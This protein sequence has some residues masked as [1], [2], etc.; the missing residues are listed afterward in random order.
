MSRQKRYVYKF[1][2]PN[3]MVY[4]GVT[5]DP[6]TRWQYNGVLY[7]PQAV[8]KAIKRFG[9]ENIKKEIVFYDPENEQAVLDEEKR[10][11]WKYQDRCYNHLDNPEWEYE[12]PNNAY[13]RR[14]GYV[15][16]WTIDGEIK[17][18]QD[19]CKVY[20]RDL[21]NTLAK[22]RKYELSPLEALTVPIV[23]PDRKMDALAYWKERGFLLEKDTRSYVTPLEEWPDEFPKADILK[24]KPDAKR[25]VSLSEAINE[26]CRRENITKTNL[27]KGTNKNPAT[28]KRAI[29]KN[30][31]TVET[32]IEIANSVGYNVIL[33]KSGTE[34]GE[35]IVLIN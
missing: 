29:E 34:K 14:G 9:W 20:S 18:A 8:G 32:L 27:S 25:G 13:G 19:W 2:F 24:E 5:N 17:P 7:A 1:T 28:I 16:V 26:L 23:P 11:I 33:A 6:E 30:G 3:G 35:D 31:T 21:S 22:M 4:I 10:L 12:K 15:H